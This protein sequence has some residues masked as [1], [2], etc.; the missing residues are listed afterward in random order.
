M[1]G[2]LGVENANVKLILPNTVVSPTDVARIIRE[3]KGLDEFFRQSEIREGGTPQNAPRYSRLLDSMVVENKLNLIQQ[4]DRSSLIEVLE[5][6]Q[7]KAP[8][9]HMS[10][11]VDPPGPYVQKIVFWLRQHIDETILVRVGLQPNIG[12]GC[13][14]RTENKSFDFSLRKFFDSKRE[15]FI[16]KLH[17]SIAPSSSEDN[18]PEEP[19]PE[20]EVTPS[21]ELVE[22]QPNSQELSGVQQ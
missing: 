8:V 22:Q 9:L 10:F 14:V 1:E 11:S 15:F 4:E 18:Q 12:A 2:L 19:V 21:E 17:E 13:I 5:Q 6:L 7:N 20:P 3:I 16:Q